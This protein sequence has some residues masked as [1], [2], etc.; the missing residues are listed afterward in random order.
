MKTNTCFLLNIWSSPTR[1]LYYCLSE[2]HRT[3]SR[4]EGNVIYP[5]SA[6]MSLQTAALTDRGERVCH[7][8]SGEQVQF[9]FL[10]SQPETAV[11]GSEFQLIILNRRSKCFSL[12]HCITLGVFSSRFSLQK[13]FHFL[14]CSMHVSNLKKCMWLATGSLNDL[15]CF[16]IKLTLIGYSTV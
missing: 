11:A 13:I 7:L 9:C 1:F 12:H 10:G 3:A 4:T 6:Y 15:C 2:C 5:P 16:Y 14:S 8:L